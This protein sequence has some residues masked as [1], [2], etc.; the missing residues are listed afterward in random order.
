MSIVSLTTEKRKGQNQRRRHVEPNA[1][2][3]DLGLQHNP[4]YFS[5]QQVPDGI[6]TRMQWLKELRRL[7]P[8]AQKHGSILL[9]HERPIG[10]KK[11]VVP[12]SSTEI[13]TLRNSIALGYPLMP[14]DAARLRAAGQISEP[15][16]YAKDQ[17]EPITQL[18]EADARELFFEFLFDGAHEND[19]I[20]EVPEKGRSTWKK[21]F[22]APSVSKHLCGHTTIGTK[23]GKKAR[24][25]T[26]DLDRHRGT[27][28]AEEH[29]ALSL[30]VGEVLNETCSYMRFAPEVNPRNGS[31]KFFGW[32]DGWYEIDE[33]KRVGEW[34]R[35]TLQEAIPDHDFSRVEIFPSSCPQVL[36]PL[37]HD[38]IMVLDQPIRQVDSWY[39]KWVRGRKVRHYCKVQSVADYMNWVLFRDTPFDMARF[40]EVLRNAVANLPDTEGESTEPKK[41]SPK[42]SKKAAATVGLGSIGSLKGRCAEVLVGFWSGKEVP[43]TDTLNTLLGVTLRIFKFEGLTEQ[44]AV[45]WIEDRRELL[46]DTS[47][48]D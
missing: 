1:V 17:T 11:G 27:V 35:E 18:T 41:S 48:S 13:G 22:S 32:L 21:R 43:P 2:H 36:A 24:L 38:K 20:V 8:T 30:K 7:S 4:P 3:I 29:V 6:K 26:V 44:D 23:K 25:V 31:V 12:F 16:L 15:Y 14:T 33:A 46:P 42:S 47:F 40:E 10:T 19:F 39:Q 45:G 28:K 34:V 37:R 5:W 9:L